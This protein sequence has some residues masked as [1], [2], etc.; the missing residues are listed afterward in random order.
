MNFREYQNA[1]VRTCIH[2]RGERSERAISWHCMG[3]AGEAGEIVD[4][5]KKVLYHGQPLDVFAVVGEIGDLLWYLSAT[6]H[7]LG[8][9]LED[10]A[11]ANINKLKTRFPDGWSEADAL[12]QRDKNNA[13]LGD[14]K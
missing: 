13:L 10:C 12:A 11:K 4:L 5:L 1:A 2:K 14:E 8:V 6:C 9:E 7:V 3:I